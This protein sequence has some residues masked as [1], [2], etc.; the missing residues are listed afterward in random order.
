MAS[1][2]GSP[3]RGKNLNELKIVVIGDVMLNHY[4]FGDVTRI[5]PEG[6]FPVL[7]I[8]HETRDLGGAGGVFAN[9]QALGVEARIIGIIGEDPAAKD[10]QKL[11]GANGIFIVATDRPTILKTRF[12]GNHAQIMRADREKVAPLSPQDEDKIIQAALGEIAK[13]QVLILSDY[14]KGALTKK[15][16]Q[17]CIRA[18]NANNIPVLVDPK[19][20]DFAIYKGADVVTPNRKELSE[21]TGGKTENDS[22]IEATAQKCLELSGIKSIVATRSEDGMSVLESK[23]G[24]AVHLKADAREVFDVSG[25]GDTVIATLATGLALG[26]SLQ[27]AASLA[28]RAAGIVVSKRGVCVITKEELFGMDNT[29]D[30]FELAPAKEKIDV[31]KAQGLKVGFTNGC[32]DILHAGHVTYLKEARSFCDRL[33]L[34]LNHDNSVRLLKGPTRPVN[35]QDDRATVMAGLGSVDMVVLFGAEKQGDDNTPVDLIRYL[36]PDIIFKGGD[37]REDQLPEAAV[38]RSYGGDVKLMGLSE[39]RSTTNIINK[40]SAA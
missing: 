17:E 8:T 33:V 25:A 32:F 14:G 12:V 2:L 16:L 6:P 24:K 4:V 23:N 30:W 20:K 37:Y 21:A 18:A 29:K 35:G 22:E 38:V 40:I 34:G 28:N 36:K 26:L 31:W 27:E 5:S 39:G 1:N 9:L 13:A 10:I 19:G 3:I 11:S 7:S 15:V